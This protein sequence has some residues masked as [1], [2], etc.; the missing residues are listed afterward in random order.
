MA[1][2]LQKGRIII[3]I[4]V[5]FKKTSTYCT[6]VVG[7]RRN[8]YIIYS[9]EGIC[10]KYKDIVTHYPFLNGGV[11]TLWYWP[12]MYYIFFCARKLAISS[13]FHIVTHPVSPKRDGQT[14]F[15]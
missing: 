6:V 11:M 9:F 3:T 12:T 4:K 10:R 1:R 2:I 13:F 15:F 14:S 7:G 5:L 8:N